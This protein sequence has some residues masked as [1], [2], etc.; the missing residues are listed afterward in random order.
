MEDE[1]PQGENND[2]SFSCGSLSLWGAGG[3]EAE[4]GDGS[5]KREELGKGVAGGGEKG[6]EE[7]TA[8]AEEQVELHIQTERERRRKMSGM[9]GALHALI[10]HLPP[11]TD[12]ATIVESA[13][14]Y[15]RTL[16]ERLQI[17][18][19]RKQEKLEQA[20][21]GVGFNPFPPSPSSMIPPQ[22]HPP[23]YE[24]MALL[25]DHHLHSSSSSR[26]ITPPN[27][28]PTTPTTHN[29]P[30]SPIMMLNPN[31]NSSSPRET[32]VKLTLSSSSIMFRT[33]TSK[34]VVLCVCGEEASFNICGARRPGFYTGIAS[35]LDKY[36]LEVKSCHISS[37]TQSNRATL[38]IQA[39]ATALLDQYPAEEI[40]KRAAVE[41][42]QVVSF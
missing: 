29:A 8:A 11:K 27:S 4:K 9:F 42:V 31:R 23:P 3:E 32:P 19:H 20:K 26:S 41:M 21:N 22:P 10:P 17:L 2:V 25:A 18:Q 1:K 35:V 6:E 37:D 13:V 39:Q 40:Y 7:G 16:E 33:F 15:V 34:N 28:N 36:R 12:K 24:P 30:G 14:S 38:M 5:A